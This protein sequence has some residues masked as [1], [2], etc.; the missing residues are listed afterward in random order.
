MTK[1]V[2]NTMENIRDRIYLESL[3]Y[4]IKDYLGY[5]ASSDFTHSMPELDAD[6]HGQ[7]RSIIEKAY[8]LAAGFPA[9]NT[10]RTAQYIPLRPVMAC[11]STTQQIPVQPIR[12]DKGYFPTDSHDNDDY[13]L[14]CL[15]FTKELERIKCSDIRSYAESLLTLLLKYASCLAID[16]A[17][18][19]VPAYDYI[20]IAAAISIC[21]YD[22]SQSAETTNN[23]FLLIGGDVSGIQQYIYQVVSKYA[24]KNLKGRSFYIRL[25]S[26]AIVRY[27]LKELDLY[28]ANV[29]YNSGGSFYILAPDTS[30]TREKLDK[31]ISVI[32]QKLFLTHNTTL[33]VAIDSVEINEDMLYG[34][35]LQDKWGELFLKRDGKKYCRYAKPI[36]ENYDRFFTPF[37]QGGELRPDS[38][39]G[40]EFRPGEEQI[41]MDNLVLKRTTAE[42]IILGKILRETDVMVVSYE[43][44]AGIDRAHT[45]APASLGIFY[46]FMKKE[47]LSRL[48]LNLSDRISAVTLNGEDGECQFIHNISYDKCIFE[49]DFYGGNDFNGNTFEKMCENP[50]FSRLGV[51]SMDVDNLGSIFQSG[52]SPEK[53]TLPKMAT[54]SRSFDWFF[55]GYI[56]TIWK[57]TAPDNTFVI[58]S[59][60][61]DLFIVGKWDCIIDT[62]KRIRNDFME[63]G[64]HN[65]KLGISGGIAIVQPKFPLLKAAEESREEEKNAKSH[66]TKKQE[67][68][69]ISFMDTPLNWDTEFPATEK[70]KNDIVGMLK[71]DQLRKAFISKILTFRENANIK[72]HRIT[73]IRTYWMLTYD[74]KRMKE[75]TSD[76]DIAALIDL[77]INEVC[78]S[79]ASSTLG[80]YEI[81]STYHKLELWGFACRW[82]EL[83][84]RSEKQNN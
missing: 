7:I 79:N 43:Q 26:D 23:Q 80:G 27:I 10:P 65:P 77:C 31:A 5:D 34:S 3:L 15:S 24:G 66:S 14:L 75:R 6:M 18:M 32:E 76:K 44:I 19:D 37:M 62:A 57:E 22:K 33:Y 16:E 51:L 71:S 81:D 73:D 1:Q 25:L 68:N 13:N 38:I 83:E 74:M 39:T 8:S 56:N 69:S 40:E 11:T 70:L 9:E 47:E 35:N 84:K 60:G 78:A 64:C 17:N 58:Y 54:L 4:H 61:D 52:L 72:N 50:E 41:K 63:Y 36:K 20:K 45:F 28:R 29:I 12:Y 46:H 30:E 59:G 2:L 82:A 48:Q 42:Q 49:L 21:L 55:S 67:K 53:V